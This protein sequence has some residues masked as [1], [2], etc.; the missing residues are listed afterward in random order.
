[1]TCMKEKRITTSNRVLKSKSIISTEMLGQDNEGYAVLQ[2]CD[3]VLVHRML[4][5][6]FHKSLL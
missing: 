2:Y 3:K 6:G 5:R 4:P 1:M